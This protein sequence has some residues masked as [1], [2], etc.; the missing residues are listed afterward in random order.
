M[1]QLKEIGIAIHDWWAEYWL[2]IEIA[3]VIGI[4]L[5]YYGTYLYYEHIF[6]W[7]Y[8]KKQKKDK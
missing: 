3:F 5:L 1:E 4:I 2:I 8:K 6:M 7:R